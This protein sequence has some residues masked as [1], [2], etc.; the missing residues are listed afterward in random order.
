MQT[1]C[2]QCKRNEKRISHEI[3]KPNNQKIHQFNR[4]L[5]AVNTSINET[6]KTIFAHTEY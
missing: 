2:T 4:N 5:E 1:V 6:K 3:E